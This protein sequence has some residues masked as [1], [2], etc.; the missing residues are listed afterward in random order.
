MT[1][2]IPQ[3]PASV[4]PGPWG[5]QQR[6]QWDPGAQLACLGLLGHNMRV[7]GEVTPE[8]FPA[9]ILAVWG[10]ESHWGPSQDVGDPAHL[11]RCSPRKPGPVR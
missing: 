7:L 6:L 5:P 1:V 9:L 3:P 4:S 10:S 8:D 2:T 11:S